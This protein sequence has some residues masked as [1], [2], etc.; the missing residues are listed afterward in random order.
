MGSLNQ[1]IRRAILDVCNVAEEDVK[2]LTDDS[3]LFGPMSVW[4]FD[5]IDAIALITELEKI[6]DIS[7]DE[8]EIKRRKAFESINT[9]VRYLYDK[10]VRPPA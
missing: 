6:F 9:I 8:D 3:S 1:I 2:D 5:S 7:L 10:G 4:D